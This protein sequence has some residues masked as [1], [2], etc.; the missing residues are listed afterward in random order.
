[1]RLW[2]RSLFGRTALL[3]AGVVVVSQALSVVLLYSLYIGARLDRAA[4]MLAGEFKTLTL[5]LEALPPS[6]H[7]RYLR[8]LR[9]E[10]D[11]RVLPLATTPGMATPDRRRARRLEQALRAQLGEPIAIRWDASRVW[12]AWP[13]TTPRAWIGLPFVAL[14]RDPA[15]VVGVW[16]G[17]GG[18]LGLLAALWIARRIDRP[19]RTLSEAA[20]QL[21]RGDRPRDLPERGPSEIA[22]LSRTFNQMARD[23][24]RLTADRTLLL[25]GVSHDLR[26]PLARLRLALEMLDAGADVR[27]KEGMVQDVDDMD[28]IVEQF[29]AYVRDGEIEA[30]RASD[31]DELIRITAARYQRQGKPLTLDLVPLPP[32]ALRVTAMQRL[33]ANLIDNALRH[34]G[35]DV[36]VRTRLLAAHAV[37]SVLDRGPGIAPPDARASRNGYGLGLVVV[38]R[39]AQLHGGTLKLLARDGGGTEARVELPL[40]AL[41]PGVLPQR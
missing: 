39:I 15:R 14:E 31:L 1:M 33:L 26:T 23:V 24:E 5:A 22:A 12:L 11:I 27:L 34:G 7:L 17:I 40:E 8:A 32:L 21:G 19:L 41:V 37:V 25:A 3:V 13:A 29:L 35:G 10:R 6:E 4:A 9:A 2:P 20:A 30:V 16:L 38:E 36:E 18:T 28:R